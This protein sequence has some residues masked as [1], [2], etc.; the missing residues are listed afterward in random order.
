MLSPEA[1]VLWNNALRVGICCLLGAALQFWAFLDRI[2]LV[3]LRAAVS[4]AVT[5][6]R[7]VLY[8]E[9][10]CYEAA[11]GT[12]TT[13]G[14][15]GCSDSTLGPPPENW[16]RMWKTRGPVCGW[17]QLLC[18]TQA[19]DRWFSWWGCHTR[20]VE[21]ETQMGTQQSVFWEAH[22][23]YHSRSSLRTT[24]FMPLS[25]VYAPNF[26]QWQLTPVS[27][28]T[29]HEA[30]VKC[31]TVRNCRAGEANQRAIHSL[32]AQMIKNL[33]AMRKTWVWSLGREDALEKQTATQSSIC[34][35]RIPW[36][37]EPS[38]AG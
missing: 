37:E 6:E 34:A 2:P 17:V 15:S 3:A 33:P 8:C 18:G 24:A 36:T 19:S 35:W 14:K 13:D 16:T 5:W 20:A 11:I 12:E 1:G 31:P 26:W 21:S 22:G 4:E 7:A 32:V 27:F 29:S 9:S 28:H 10:C 30:R 23:D 38:L 25:V